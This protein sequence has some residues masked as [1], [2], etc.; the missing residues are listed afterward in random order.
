VTPRTSL[1][2]TANI[3]L[4]NAGDPLAQDFADFG[5]KLEVVS[6][7]GSV[8]VVG[9]VTSLQDP[10]VQALGLDVKKLL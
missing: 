3:T 2:F 7:K 1:S 9:S 4:L 10:A 5:E 8:A 6:K